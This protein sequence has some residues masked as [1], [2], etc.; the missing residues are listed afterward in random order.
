MSNMEDASKVF[1]S[2][3]FSSQIARFLS[4]EFTIEESLSANTRENV[5]L[6]RKYIENFSDLEREYHLL[7]SFLKQ[8]V[9]DNSALAHIPAIYGFSSSQTEKYLREPLNWSH[10]SKQL[11][12]SKTILDPIISNKA[13]KINLICEIAL[14]A[15]CVSMEEMDAICKK[16]LSLSGPSENLENGICKWWFLLFS[17]YSGTLLCIQALETI[18]YPEFICEILFDNPSI[19]RDFY[20]GCNPFAQKEA[21]IE[22]LKIKFAHYLKR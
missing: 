14:S 5:E 17:W 13:H 9:C 1:E 4:Q 21:I 8:P 7:P 22:Q 3:G 20:D 19:V 12:N 16:L 15:T 2:L 6:L 10:I 11:T 18:F